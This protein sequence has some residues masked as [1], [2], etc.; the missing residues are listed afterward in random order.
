MHPETDILVVCD[1]THQQNVVKFNQLKCVGKPRVGSRVRMKWGRVT[2][3]GTII[4]IEQYGPPK[5]DS[6]DN[7]ISL[8]SLRSK[9]EQSFKSDIM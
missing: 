5:D 9:H 3:I 7:D 6:S 8:A 4:D 1:N 2:W